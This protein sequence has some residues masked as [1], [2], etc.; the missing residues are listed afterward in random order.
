MK[1]EKLR[2]L[3]EEH[4]LS[5]KRIEDSQEE[6]EKLEDRYEEVGELL[7]GFRSKG[8][9][10]SVLAHL[11]DLRG[12]FGKDQHFDDLVESFIH[13]LKNYEHIEERKNFTPRHLLYLYD[14]KIE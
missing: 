7:Y 12:E 4:L 9:L 3:I 5:R 1:K 6:L 10:Q 8:F 14:E 13:C 11:L 2:D